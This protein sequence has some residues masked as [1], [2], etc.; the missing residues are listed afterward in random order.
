MKRRDM[1]R[2]LPV[3]ALAAAGFGER[4]FAKAA[5]TMDACPKCGQQPCVCGPDNSSEALSAQYL[6]KVTDM[7]K[8]IRAT[9]S[10]NLLEAAYAIARTVEKKG[11]CWYSWDMGHSTIMDLVPGRNALPEIFTPGYDSGKSKDGDLFLANIWGG[12]H[13]DLAKKDILV[14]GGPAPWGMDAQL[15]E[16]IVRDSAKVRLRPYSDIWIETYVSTV[17]AI[18]KLPGMPAPTDPVSGIIGMVTFWMMMADACRILA[19]DG[20]SVP[21]RGDEPSLSGTA[22]PWV[23]LN[24]PLMDDYFD[25]VIKQMEMILA[26]LGNIQ[27]IAKMAADSVLSGGKVY[28]YSRHQMALCVEAQTRRGGLA[29]TRGVYVKDGAVVDYPGK[30]VEG[31]PNDLV[32]MGAYRPDD[33]V[34]LESL[35]QFR[36]GKMK[37]ASIGPMTRNI[38]EP[39]GRSLPREN[40]YPCWPHVRHLRPFR[41]SRFRAEDLPDLRRT[42]QSDMVGDLHG[43]RG[44]DH[45]AHTATPPVSISRRRSKAAQNTCTA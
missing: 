27:A 42:G 2:M 33:P 34:D 15:S 8:K 35:K 6:H 9:Q 39:D 44:R 23:N 14:I 25:T 38:K 37:V 16:L 43:N 13:E 32:I 41:G 36:K 11:T 12:P 29:L 7:L 5:K 19:R 10:E 26:E 4:S 45:Q 20:H 3:S 22:V 18:M 40:R 24:A 17:G 31:S 28:G 30:V 21:V 1:I